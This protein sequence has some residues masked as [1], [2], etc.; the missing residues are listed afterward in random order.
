MNDRTRLILI[1]AALFLILVVGVVLFILNR[2]KAPKSAT[3]TDKIV[4]TY[5]GLW[6]PESA[7][8]SLFERYEV[9]HPNIDIQYVQKPFTQY[10]STVFTRIQQ[11]IVD[12]TPAPDVIRI[13]NAWLSKFQPS[14]SPLPA[15]IMTA[16]DYSQDFY[17]T[18]VRDFTGTDG[19]IYAIPLEIDGLAV[20]YN[21]KLLKAASMDVPPTDWDTFIEAAKKLTKKNNAGKITQG[22]VA[23]GSAKNIKHSADIFS[24]LLLQNNVPII[25][26][27]NDE[28][29]ITSTRSESALDF[30]TSFTKVHK[31]W[32]DELASDLEMFYS[33]KLA[34]MFGPS[35]RAFDIIN[36]NATIEFGISPVPQLPSNDP[37]N[38]AMYWGEAVTRSS[39]N[40]LEAWKLVKWL[41][42]QSQMKEFYSNSAKIRAFGEP[43]SRKS[44]SFELE[45]DP[46]AGAFMQMAPTFTAWKM[47]DQVF[48]EESLR[49]AI[50]DVVGRGVRI[51][52]ALKDAQDRINQRLSEVVK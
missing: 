30:Y 42:E 22:G 34:M 43:Y 12:D 40:Q 18:A 33:G 4:L 2:N 14:L 37:V 10:E 47:G 45:S 28:V 15:S 25:N 46:Y 35:W 38:Y 41:S 9:D 16:S 49:T 23:L 21:K 48:I 3:N 20:F 39:P 11:N 7:M 50:N 17:P 32:G 51:P 13:N 52:D 27:T 6:E 24:L 44:M 26:S 5:W 29:N 31:V 8:Q 36:A 1:G 19:E